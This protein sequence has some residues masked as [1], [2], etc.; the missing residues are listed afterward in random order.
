MSAAAGLALALG[1]ALALNWGWVAQHGAASSL[2]KLSLRRPLRALG[3]LFRDLSW[4]TG[5]LVGLLGWA[6]Y[7]A[8]LALAPLSV[9]QAISAGGVGILA[10]LAFWRGE[11]VGRGQWLAVAVSITGL[12]LL[13]VSLRGGTF[14]TA[15]PASGALAL[16]LTGSI[17]L[18]AMAAVCGSRL[19][20]GAGLGVAA[21]LLYAAGDVATKTATFA[22]GRL[23]LVPLVL[24]LHGAAF[25]ALQLGFQR[26]SALTTAG[27]ATVLTNALPI[28]GGLLLFHEHVPGNTL[29]IVRILAFA[30]TVA[31]AA[32][33]V[34]RRTS[35]GDAAPGNAASTMPSDSIPNFS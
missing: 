20:A 24:L 17:A 14:V 16:W 3:A 8:A 30:C 11:D 28:V 6:M 15:A 33:L 13:G 27:P 2:P 26:G 4:L 1:S 22:G 25:V 18:A 21:G 5:F 7:V 12:L 19:T 10:A 34:A 23:L 31:G 9:V 35:G 29:G 32:A